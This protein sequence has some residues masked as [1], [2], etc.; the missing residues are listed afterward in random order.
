MYIKPL[1]KSTD[2]IYKVVWV[3]RTIITGLL[4]LIILTLK[5]RQFLIEIDLLDL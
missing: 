4:S 5:Y 3:V 2:A 1:R